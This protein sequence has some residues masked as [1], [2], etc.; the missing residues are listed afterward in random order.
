MKLVP[1]I[2]TIVPGGPLA[3]PT[4]V[5]FGAGRTVNASLV[6]VALVL[7]GV[8]TVIST[9][10]LPDGTIAR[11]AVSVWTVNDVAAVD[12]KWT[13]VVPVKPLPMTSTNELGSPLLGETLTTF[14][15]GR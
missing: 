10:P 15:T 11:I 2:P 9:R 13:A 14:G 4:A 3:G 8:V 1:P 6:L 5:T 12:P 7:M